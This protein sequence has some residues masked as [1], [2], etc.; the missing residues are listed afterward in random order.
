MT[1]FFSIQFGLTAALFWL[2]DRFFGIVCSV[3]K[4]GFI[5]AAAPV[6]HPPEHRVLADELLFLNELFLEFDDDPGGDGE[7]LV[8]RLRLDIVLRRPGLLLRFLLILD[9]VFM[10]L[11]DVQ[12]PVPVLTKKYRRNVS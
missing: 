2:R 6:P 3:C 4:L 1:N 5:L 7:E 11:P 9:V 8:Q 10:S 12:P